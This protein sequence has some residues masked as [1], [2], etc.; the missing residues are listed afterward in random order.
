MDGFGK[1]AE[2]DERR[3]ELRQELLEK[4]RYYL[5][6]GPMIY[7]ESQHI[8][9]AGLAQDLAPAPAF[10]VWL[11]IRQLEQIGVVMP[12]QF[13]ALRTYASSFAGAAHKHDPTLFNWP[14]FVVTPFG[15]A[16][17][18]GSAEGA[19]PGDSVRFV[20]SLITRMPNIP[21]VAMRYVGEA[22]A[23]YG[24]NLWLATTVLLGVAAEALLEYLYDCLE[25]HLRISE[26]A[27]FRAALERR[28]RSADGRYEVFKD[29]MLPRHAAELGM[30]LTRRFDLVLEPLLRLMKVNRD[31]VAHRRVTRV[32]RETA[33][34]ELAS[35]PALVGASAEL[36]AALGSACAAP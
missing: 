17:L 19:D 23:S 16:Y 15:R 18:D 31:D 29:H 6:R 33:Y 21:D 25:R 10:E 9:A 36:E 20:S 35:F 27:Q 7:S 34:A 8:N 14:F 26:R 13:W 32:D 4:L 22:A 11:I 30:E 2:A 1:G 28:K 12:G 3:S 24:R 5:Q